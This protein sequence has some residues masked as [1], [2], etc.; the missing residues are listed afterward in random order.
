MAGEE[1]GV[2]VMDLYPAC[3]V[4]TRSAACSYGFQPSNLAPGN[5]K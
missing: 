3:L 2:Y 5:R 4:M 1:G